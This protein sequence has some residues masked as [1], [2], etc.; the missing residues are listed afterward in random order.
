M[1]TTLLL[2]HIHSVKLTHAFDSFLLCTIY[3][4]SKDIPMHPQY[5][6]TFT[7]GD[8]AVLEMGVVCSV[9]ERLCN[10]TDELK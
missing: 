8:L 1:V 7:F 10:W 2:K 9:S 3:I 5:I 4:H 6:E